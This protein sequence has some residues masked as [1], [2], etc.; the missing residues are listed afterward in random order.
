[1][2]VLNKQS[3]YGNRIG[4]IWAVLGL[5]TI[6]FPAHALYA[7][8]PMVGAPELR[9]EVTTTN[10][11]NYLAFSNAF[12][13]LEAK[14]AEAISK[15]TS[16]ATASATNTNNTNSSGALS[17]TTTTASAMN[18]RASSVPSG[19]NVYMA[20]SPT[21]APG[22]ETDTE[23]DGPQPGNFAF[24]SS[25]ASDLLTV[26]PQMITQYLKPEANETNQLDRHGVVVFVPADM[27]FM[28][29][30]QKNVPESRAIYQSR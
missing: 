1:M 22:W 16:M 26:T 25:S 8:L 30:T 7:Y 17:T 11:F 20:S 5:F 27:P 14:T 29:P 13:A 28:P 21:S 3:K 9:I 23:K 18:N 19:A 12:A 24:P 2:N 15:A 10:S 4:L 6:V